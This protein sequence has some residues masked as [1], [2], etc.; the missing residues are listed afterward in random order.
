MKFGAGADFDFDRQAARTGCPLGPLD[1]G[2]D[3]AGGGDVVVFNEDGVE[4]S[5]AVVGDAASGR[6]GL[7]ERAQAGGCLAGVEDAAA[8]A[9][10]GLGEL[11]R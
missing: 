8:C 2:A 6:G 7:F 11:A 1:G 4:E 3:T 5:H 9:F 10:D